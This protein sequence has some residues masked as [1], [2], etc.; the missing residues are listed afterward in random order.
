MRR[1]VM[2]VLLTAAA[3]LLGSA[4][5]AGAQGTGEVEAVVVVT[6][7]A[8][9]GADE[10]L[11]TVVIFD[12]PATIDGTVREQVVAFNG[13]VRVSGT[14]EDDVVSLNGRVTVAE[15]GRVGGDVVSRQPAVVDPG[16]TVDGALRRFDP[17]VFDAWFGVVTR[18]AW[19]LA[20]SV[21]ALVLGLLLLWLAPRVVEA[22][23]AVGRTAIGPVIGWGLAALVA[24]PV[25]AVILMVT[26]VGLPL[27]LYLLAV[28]GVLGVLGYT[29]SAWILGRRLVR[30]PEARVPAFLAGL[31]VLRVIALVLAAWRARAASSPVAAAPGQR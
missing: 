3:V 13:D 11:E 2:L 17:Q 23:V 16:A 14:V 22:T 21:S 5:P 7:R 25:A 10:E 1:T 6:G 29:V 18:L 19:W 20:V 27:G 9:V 28:V 8:D 4:A 30:G 12:G 31:A 15:G 26:V 24:A